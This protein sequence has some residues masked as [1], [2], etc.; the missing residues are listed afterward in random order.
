MYDIKP[1][2]VIGFHG[3]ERAVRDQL[4]NKPNKIVY[5]RQPYDWLGHGMYFWENNYTRAFQWAEG[6]LQKRP[7][8]LG[9]R[10]KNY[11]I[12]PSHCPIV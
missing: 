7:L 5:S 3:C 9:K 12:S 4:L 8:I 2:L 1:N 10:T 6:N 11:L